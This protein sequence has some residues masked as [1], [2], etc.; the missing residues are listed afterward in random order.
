[1]APTPKNQN[2]NEIYRYLYNNPGLSKQALAEKLELSIPT[3]GAALKALKEEGLIKYDGMLESTGGRK[4]RAYSC[5]YEAKLALGMDITANH[6]ALVLSDMK[7]HILHSERIRLKFEDKASYYK[8][9]AEKIAAFIV[10][11]QADESKILGL[12]VCL[13]ALVAPDNKTI[14]SSRQ[15]GAPKDLYKKLSKV[16]TMPFLIFNDANAGGFAEFW[17]M[18]KDRTIVYLSLNHN[19]GGSM[20]SHGKIYLGDNLKSCEF[21]HMTLVPDGKL[22]A[23]GKKGC[24]NAYLS[25]TLLSDMADGKMDDFFSYVEEGKEPFRSTFRDYRHKLAIVVNNLRMAYDCDIVLGGYVG[26]RMGPYL[27]SCREMVKERSRFQ[28]E[29]GFI[30]VCKHRYENAAIGASLYYIDHFIRAI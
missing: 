25:A 19:V 13:A 23:C 10:E 30:R 9:V 7:A 5:D 11:S 17:D 15:L 24:V 3:V 6:I 26:S 21:G 16:I 22:C 8:K 12:G 29:S 27:D 1:M 2:R 18:D 28:E 4:A 14:T 20:V